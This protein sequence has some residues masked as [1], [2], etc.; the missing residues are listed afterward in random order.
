MFRLIKN[1]KKKKKKR[2]ASTYLNHLFVKKTKNFTKSQ[3][4]DE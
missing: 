4:G 3:D 2:T 1:N